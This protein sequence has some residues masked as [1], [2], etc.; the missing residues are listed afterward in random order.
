MQDM[1]QGT[2]ADSTHETF[3]ASS[4]PHYGL[5]Q[6][7]QV[8]SSTL[9]PFHTVGFPHPFLRVPVSL[10]T[11]KSSYSYHEVTPPHSGLPLPGVDGSPAC[12][13]TVGP[14]EVIECMTEPWPHTPTLALWSSSRPYHHPAFVGEEIEA[15]WGQEFPHPVC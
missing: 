9:S 12:I 7:K 6:A 8:C 4:A 15:Q 10:P 2:C 11:T 5:L 3:S 1:V 13:P 14:V